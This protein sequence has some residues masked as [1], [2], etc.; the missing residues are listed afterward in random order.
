MLMGIQI[1]LVPLR[2]QMLMAIQ[3]HLVLCLCS[4]FMVLD[5][6]KAY[7]IGIFQLM[8]GTVLFVSGCTAGQGHSS[9]HVSPDQSEH[10]TVGIHQCDKTHTG[11]FPPGSRFTPVSY[12]C[13]IIS[14]ASS[15]GPYPAALPP[16]RVPV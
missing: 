16:E 3:V 10:R 2:F 4:W 7:S 6:V 14:S 12:E 8:P 13:L 15:Q 9:V 1:H 5:L 11:P